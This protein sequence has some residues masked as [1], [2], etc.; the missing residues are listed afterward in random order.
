VRLRD[1]HDHASRCERKDI[2]VGS[3]MVAT[4]FS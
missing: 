2:H 1:E 4:E 3:H